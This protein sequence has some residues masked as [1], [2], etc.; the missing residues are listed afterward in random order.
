MAKVVEPLAIALR[1]MGGLLHKLVER[2]EALECA[3]M[4]GDDF[5][6]LEFQEFLDGLPPRA[7]VPPPLPLADKGV[8]TEDDQV[9][10]E[11]GDVPLTYIEEEI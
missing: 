4:D 1:E 7:E 10:A 11:A 2:V 6:E 5:P 8:G 9:N 3:A